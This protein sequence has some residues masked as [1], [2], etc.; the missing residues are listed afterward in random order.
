MIE[1]HKPLPEGASADN[2]TGHTALLRELAEADITRVFVD[3]L[4]QYRYPSIYIEGGDTQRLAALATQLGGAG[5]FTIRAVEGG[6]RV[7]KKSEPKKLK[8][9]QRGRPVRQSDEQ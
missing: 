2:R 6:C 3:E 9:D 4:P 1:Y 5:W 7:W 8:S